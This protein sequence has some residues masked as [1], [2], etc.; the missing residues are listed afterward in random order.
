MTR[1]VNPLDDTLTEL[2]DSWMEMMSMANTLP[3]GMKMPIH[4]SSSMSNLGDWEERDGVIAIT[5]DMPGIEKEEIEL[6]VDKNTVKVAAVR[7]T[8]DYSFSKTFNQDLNPDTAT[9]EFNNGVLDIK[10]EI[11]EEFKGKQIDIK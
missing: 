4:N 5:V 6:N 8:R 9:A 2:L 11:A 3:K 10:I 7:D 1:K